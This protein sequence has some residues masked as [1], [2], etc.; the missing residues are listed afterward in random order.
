MGARSPHPEIAGLATGS[1]E[2]GL[3]SRSRP[4]PQHR[5]PRAGL[6]VPALLLARDRKSTRLNSSHVR[7]S[8]AVFCLKKKTIQ[9]LCNIMII[10][11]ETI[12][13][14]LYNKDLG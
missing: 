5:T 11:V 6:C 13:D 2:W 10:K 7:I 12:I 3:A 14:C 4:S 1:R 8:Y 9:Y